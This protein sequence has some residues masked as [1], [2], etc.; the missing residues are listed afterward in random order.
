M[1]SALFKTL[2]D[3]PTTPSRILAIPV[4]P[5]VTGDPNVWLADMKAK[6][7]SP[8]F[9]FS[10]RVKLFADGAFFAQYMQMNPPGYSDGHE[11]KWLTEPEE[12]LKQTNR[13]W[14]A[15]WNLH[16]HVN[17]DKGAYVCFK[18]DFRGRSPVGLVAEVEGITWSEARAYI[19]KR[20]IK[21]RRKDD[22][23]TVADRIRALRERDRPVEVGPVEY[24]LP[25]EFKPCYKDGKWSLPEYLKQ[26]RIKSDTAR[27]WGLGWCRVGDYA[28]RLIIPIECP[29]GYSFTARDMTG[30]QEPKY[31]N[32]TGADHR[33][34]LIGWNV[35]KRTGDLCLAE[36]PL[37]VIK[38]DQNG[39]P[40][41]AV[42]GKVLHSDQLAM[43]FKLPDSAA[44]TVMLDPEEALAPFD[45]ASQLAVH[46]DRIYIAHLP[47]GVD[48]GD[49]SRRQASSAV[50]S[51]TPYTGERIAPLKNRLV[52]LKGKYA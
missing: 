45:M 27:R 15:G 5:L 11:G 13:F 32:P 43:L 33:R 44:V 18:C 14:D 52:G 25:R 23:F 1:E 24:S 48:P 41:M 38:L 35:V 16:T 29:G 20:S 49:A 47:E 10:N 50:E 34:L 9:F 42:G 3:Q 4:A 8:K 17:G 31:V 28:G 51:A 36:G 22:V 37:D 7:E 30:E 2:Y 19:F 39:I 46:F 6:Y 21:L 12:L 40:A 26:R